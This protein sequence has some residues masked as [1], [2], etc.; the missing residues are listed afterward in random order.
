MTITYSEQKPNQA[1]H[2]LLL[3]NA[4]P[5]WPELQNERVLTAFNNSTYAASALDEDD[6]LIGTI[7][8]ISDNTGFALI[9]DLLVDPKYRKQGIGSKLL[10]MCE[11]NFAGLYIYADPQEV[12]LDH[13]YE[14][15][16]Y[17]KRTLFR[18]RTGS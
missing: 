3:K 9:A 1:A 18:K 2:R 5:D 10:R 11:S 13:F 12:D 17:T 16:G 6:N 7:R 8:V 14:K 4:H 15:N